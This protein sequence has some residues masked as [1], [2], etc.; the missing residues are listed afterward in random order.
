MR[1]IRRRLSEDP[2]SAAFLHRYRKSDMQD[3]KRGIGGH[4]AVIGDFFDNVLM[5]VLAE[6]RPSEHF[7][8]MFNIDEFGVWVSKEL[9]RDMYTILFK[10]LPVPEP[11]FDEQRTWFSVITGFNY[12][13]WMVPPHIAVPYVKCTDKKARNAP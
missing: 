6:Y 7:T 1:R 8:A 3:A 12:V 9:T 4:P 5:P 11:V 13:G 2:E 10:D